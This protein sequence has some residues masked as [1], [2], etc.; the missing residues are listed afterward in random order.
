MQEGEFPDPFPPGMGLEQPPQPSA[1]LALAVPVPAAPPPGTM[2]VAKKPSRPPPKINWLGDV[3]KART[4]QLMQF[5]LPG[6]TPD[7]APFH[8]WEAKPTFGD[9]RSAKHPQGVEGWYGALW[10]HWVK[11]D[12]SL[13]IPA[14][15][16]AVVATK[17]GNVMLAAG[18]SL[19]AR[20]SAPTSF[21]SVFSPC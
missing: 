12:P 11:Q 17:N 2:V 21:F 18:S 16:P 15:H 7:D 1:T 13:S 6:Q 5:L 14:D 8:G 9:W 3:G 19:Q 20:V 10:Q 4:C